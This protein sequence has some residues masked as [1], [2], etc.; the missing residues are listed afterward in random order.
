MDRSNSI[1]LVAE[2]LMAASSWAQLDNVIANVVVSKCETKNLI[3]LLEATYAGKSKLAH[4]AALLE[5]TRK[6]LLQR[7]EKADKML[8][9]L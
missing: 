8:A 3:A 6:V 1:F 7:G 2:E 9:H 4:R 5:Q